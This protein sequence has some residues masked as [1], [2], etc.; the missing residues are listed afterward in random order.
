MTNPKSPASL[1]RSSRRRNSLSPTPSRKNWSPDLICL[2]NST[3]HYIYHTTRS[4]W[5]ARKSSR[6]GSLLPPREANATRMSPFPRFM[7]RERPLLHLS[8]NKQNFSSLP[9]LFRATVKSSVP[10]SHEGPCKFT[11]WD[12][13]SFAQSSNPTSNTYSSLKGSYRPSR[14]SLKLVS[15]SMTLYLERLS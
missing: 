2:L 6:S 11:A 14:S 5:R 12:W 7:P 15:T 9:P 13:G 8:H 10:S 3:H 1:S 4:G